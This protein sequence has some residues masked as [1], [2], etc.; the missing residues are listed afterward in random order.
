MAEGPGA[1][2][3]TSMYRANSSTK[4]TT[5]EPAA[6]L[7]S[8]PMGKELVTSTRA[9]LVMRHPPHASRHHAANW[10]RTG[11]PLEFNAELTQGAILA[12]ERHPFDLCLCGQN[13]IEGIRMGLRIA[14]G[15]QRMRA[16]DRQIRRPK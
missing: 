6:S 11:L 12:D 3:C 4:S 1:T 15:S 8:P 5:N 13:A 14:T 9:G 2:T 7:P 16:R 10:P